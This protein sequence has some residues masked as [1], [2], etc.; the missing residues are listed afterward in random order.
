MS[1]AIGELL[2]TPPAS[3]KPA[4]QPRAARAV[5]EPIAKRQPAKVGARAFQQIFRGIDNVLRQE[6]GCATELEYTE[7]TS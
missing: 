7:Q 5:T 4:S 2:P 3:P 1:L 6:T